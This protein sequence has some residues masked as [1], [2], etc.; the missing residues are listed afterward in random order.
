MS[1]KRSGTDSVAAPAPP[2]REIFSFRCRGFLAMGLAVAAAAILLFVWGLARHL[3]HATSLSE[4]GLATQAV[5]RMASTGQA[6]QTV[7]PPYHEANWL[8]SRFVPVLYLLVPFFW[9]GASA[10]WLIA[11][12]AI[13]L[14]LPALGVFALAR[15]AG[16]GGRPALVW[17]LIYLANPFLWGAAGWD[18]QPEHL[19]LIFVTSALL[20]L[21]RQQL[22]LW[23]VS[24]LLLLGCGE[25]GGWVVA[26]HGIAWWRLHRETGP[27][28]A[29]LLF[30]LGGLYLV[31]GVLMPH[32]QGAAMRPPGALAEEMA[33]RGEWIRQAPGAAVSHGLGLLLS[34]PVLSYLFL[35]FLPVLGSAL[36][37]PEILLVALPVLAANVFSP[38]ELPTS[39]Y[40]H[41]T[42]LAV[43]ALLAA[44]VIGARRLG[45]W[46]E[47]GRDWILPVMWVTSLGI[48][49]GH[50]PFPL[51]GATD[52]G[53][54]ESPRLA[55][56]PELVR[57]S[58][59]LD[60]DRALSVQSNVGSLFAA[61]SVI[62]PFPEGLSWATHVLLYLDDPRRPGTAA[63][64]IFPSPF[65]A[66]PL[67][68]RQCVEDL[69]KDSTFGV[70]HWSPPWL[71]LERGAPAASPEQRTAI[72]KSLDALELSWRPVQQ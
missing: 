42:V 24:L 5:H 17:G 45:T 54:L 27:T 65:G 63:G 46:F 30:G 50:S 1:E 8:A 2:F 55:P 32:L 29:A 47:S 22:S 18:L 53:Q 21:V 28:L 67:V 31:H 59:F 57:F 15:S 11:A 71:L 41:H 49:W 37:A 51:P 13:A 44:G 62:A 9:I 40:S 36:L 35:F 16:E 3:G 10:I 68:Y 58:P 26:L 34:G 33:R 6:L 4:L 70:R 48:A 64:T 19:G 66:E 12:Q 61:R 56:D 52:P 38:S 20:G 7:L 14:T 39:P 72:K 60:G 43:P 25:H 69:L 23:L